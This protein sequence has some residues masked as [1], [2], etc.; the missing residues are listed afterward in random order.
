MVGLVKIDINVRV[1]TIDKVV[2]IVIIS[3]RQRPLLVLRPW[4]NPPLQIN[5]LQILIQCHFYLTITG[6]AWFLL[7][8]LWWWLSTIVVLL[9]LLL[10]RLAHFYLYLHLLYLSL[11]WKCFI[12]SIVLLVC[13]AYARFY[14]S[15]SFVFCLLFCF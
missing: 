13:Y 5:T 12:Y 10:Y 2:T 8:W 4:A 9:V 1:I 14:W 15:L 7:L 3:T 11:S 6:I